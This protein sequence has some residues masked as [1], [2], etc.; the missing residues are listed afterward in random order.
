[1]DRVLWAALTLGAICWAWHAVNS[2]VDA[3]LAR[4][5]A[6]ALDEPSGA[7]RAGGAATPLPASRGGHVHAWGQVEEDPEGHAVQRCTVGGCPVAWVDG[8][9]TRL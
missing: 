6:A 2:R 7:P 4:H 3:S 5:R 1:M 9:M 8:F